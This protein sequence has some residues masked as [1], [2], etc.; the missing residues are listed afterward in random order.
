MLRRSTSAAL[1]AAASVALALALPLMPAS[2]AETIGS[3][4]GVAFEDTNRNGVPDVGETAWSGHVVYLFDER[5]SYVR[6]A[7]SDAQ[8]LYQFA[9][10]PA[11]TYSVEYASN[12]WW[13]LRENWVPSTTGSI[14]PKQR[15]VVDGPEIADFGWRAI[16]RSTTAGQPITSFTG[17]SG[18]RVDSY[19]DVIPARE[20]HDALAAGT[21]GAEAATTVV[22]FALSSSSTTAASLG[23]TDGRYDRFSAYVYVSWLSWLDQGQDTLSH[24]YGHAWGL[25]RAYLVQQDPR[26]SGYLAV[27]GLAVDDPRLDQNHE[28]G[29]DELLAEDYRQLLGPP[30]ART[31]SQ[32]NSSLPLASAVPGLRDYLLGAFSTSSPPATAP[33][34]PAAPNPLSGTAGDAQVTLSWTPPAGGVTG[35]RIYLNGTG[36]AVATFPA[37]TTI[38]TLTGLTNGLTYT[39]T[40]RAYNDGG[41]SANSSTVTRTPQAPP[42]PAAPLVVDQLTS[43]S[44]KSGIAIGFRL[45][46]Q[47]A[48]T[49]TVVDRS[50]ALVRTLTDREAMG[51]GAR[52]VLWDGKDSAGRRVRLTGLSARV[53]ADTADRRTA[54]ATRALG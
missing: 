4:S 38:V 37:P 42:P 54:T 45:S 23:A 41:E 18:L 21:V 43:S 30:A 26:L 3:I 28:W 39:Y 27:R 33:A 51:A 1:T 14:L 34:A 32:M 10:L 24:E 20:L 19:N 22:H 53:R 44:G 6:G 31:A 35:Y 46:E 15:V 36:T 50:G 40:V 47:A 52:S 13:E 2:A 11:G 49:V 29:R 48:V 17:P 8:G 16:V 7:T 12:R 5:G 25:Y 9:D